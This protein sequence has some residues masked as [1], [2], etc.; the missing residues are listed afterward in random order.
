MRLKALCLAALLAAPAFAELTTYQVDP[1][2]SSVTFT[3]RHLVSEV[4]GRFREF[5]GTVKYDPK[6][7]PASSASFNEFNLIMTP[8]LC[9]T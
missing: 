7:V 1:V 5:E 8:S 3:I 9:E 2:H 4:E 6:N